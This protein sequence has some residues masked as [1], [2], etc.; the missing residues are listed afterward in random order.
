M[1]TH[2]KSEERLIRTPSPDFFILLFCSVY[3]S[4]Y[5]A[6]TSALP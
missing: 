1:Y 6:F 5:C 2:K 4:I 3:Y